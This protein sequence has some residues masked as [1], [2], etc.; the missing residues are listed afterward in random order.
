MKKHKQENKKRQLPAL[1]A[2]GGGVDTDDLD[3]TAHDAR[4][5]RV[6]DDRE[7][8]RSLNAANHGAEGRDGHGLDHLGDELLHVEVGERVDLDHADAGWEDDATADALLRESVE[9][10]EGVQE[11]DPLA[12]PEELA[13]RALQIGA[14]DRL[15]LAVVVVAAHAQLTVD[16]LLLEQVDEALALGQVGQVLV[17]QHLELL[18][19]GDRLV[20]GNATSHDHVLTLEELEDASLGHDAHAKLNLLGRDLLLDGEDGR[21]VD[22]D[23]L[24]RDRHL[25]DRREAVHLGER[26]PDEVQ[27]A[28]GRVQDAA[29]DLV[30]G[31]VRVL[32]DVEHIDDV[33]VRVERDGRLDA[34]RHNTGTASD[35]GL[36][37]G[38]VLVVLGA[39][40]VA[41]GGASDGLDQWG[42]GLVD[43]S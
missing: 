13:A 21:T 15:E 22:L 37:D 31:E 27:V 34:T 32:S 25:L 10:E 29:I 30:A 6:E 42:L 35:D 7:D 18:E 39:V 41:D 16:L 4:G 43:E 33:L 2:S 36:A 8:V 40:R 12:S 5:D 23:V 19:L 24:E 9:L 20:D 28:G 11:G 3:A 26:L 1:D 38:R 14:E 17:H